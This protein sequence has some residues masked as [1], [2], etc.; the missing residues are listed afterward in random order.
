[1]P[2]PA[3]RDYLAPL[4]ERLGWREIGKG[5]EYLGLHL[6]VTIHVVEYAGRLTLLFHSPQVNLAAE[7]TRHFQGFHHWAA[8]GLPT[9]WLEA[10]AGD[11]HSC[12]LRIDR[13]R[14]QEIGHKRFQRLPDLIAADFEALGAP[15]QV[16]CQSC[17]RQPATVAALVHS[18]YK[19][20]CATCWQQLKD[21]HPETE[22]G[23]VVRW[24]RVL[25]VWGIILLIGLLTWGYLKHEQ[26]PDALLFVTPV[27]FGWVLGTGIRRTRTGMNWFLGT[28]LAASV[29]LVIWLGNLWAFRA[30]LAADDPPGWI[31]VLRQYFTGRLTRHPDQEI[32]YLIGG[33]FGLWIGLAWLRPL[34]RRPIR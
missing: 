1:M 22:G 21:Q 19:S 3:L 4:A 24:P 29:V 12:L 14:L 33:A 15:S 10:R 8:A 18:A 6:G 25:P 9:A 20:L 31:E 17:S 27:V 13:A 32:P 7:K 5:Y 28:G 26:A 11:E 23:P 16:T 34:E 30:T 2:L